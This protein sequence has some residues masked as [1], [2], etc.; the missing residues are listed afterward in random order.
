MGA[1]AGDAPG[2]TGESGGRGGGTDGVAGAVPLPLPTLPAWGEYLRDMPTRYLPLG[3]DSYLTL[4]GG[5]RWET[6][7][8]P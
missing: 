4:P 8:L 1:A 2:G 3:G 6:G 5:W 7:P